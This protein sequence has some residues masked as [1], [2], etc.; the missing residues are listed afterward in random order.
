VPT[1]PR[2]VQRQHFNLDVRVD[3]IENDLD[4]QDVDIDA[5]RGRI[6]RLLVTAAG[7]LVSV[8]VAVI[9]AYLTGLVGR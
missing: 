9:T 5:M 8:C 2:R 7:A 3:L 6:T 4:E 1:E